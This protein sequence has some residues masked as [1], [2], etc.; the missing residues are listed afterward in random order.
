[1]EH[2]ISVVL[3]LGSN[4]GERGTWLNAMRSA[5]VKL[6]GTTV[7]CSGI[8]ETEPL[9]VTLPH[10]WYLNQ[11]LEGGCPLPLEALFAACRGIEEELGREGKG[12][13]QARCADID[14]LLYGTDVVDTPALTVPH[15]QM[16]RR[17]FC[18]DG[19]REIDPGRRLPDGRTVEQAWCQMPRDV[20]RQEVRSAGLGAVAGVALRAAGRGGNDA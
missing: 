14:I 17:R 20:A 11:I 16:L 2:S 3:S 9:E 4:L 8:M 7:R 18:L 12:A 6:L 19:L 5:V 10:P 13:K 1:M 15:P